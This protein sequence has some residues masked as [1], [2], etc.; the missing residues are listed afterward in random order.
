MP[1]NAFYSARLGAILLLGISLAAC[2][3]FDGVSTRVASV[4]TPYK[5]DVVQGNF[6]SREQVEALQTGMGRQQVREILGTPLVTSLF[7][8]D[9]WEYVFSLQRPGQPVQSRKLTV[10]FKGDVLERFEGDEMPTESEFVASLDT[11]KGK[12][13]P[14]PLEATEEQL[15]KFPAPQ[16]SSKA[17][18]QQAAPAPTATRYPP[19]E[20]G[21][22]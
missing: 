9:R 15:A 6:I 1:A 3:S 13:K 11:R 18:E 5:V 21:T 2:G 7:H 22:R 8:A 19:L 10:F 4:V 12:R 14:L 16:A 20:S 17:A